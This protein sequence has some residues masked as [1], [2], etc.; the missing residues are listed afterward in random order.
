MAITKVSLLGADGKL[1]PAILHALLSGGFQVTVLKRASSKSKDAYPT[2]VHVAKVQDDFA[3]EALTPI[4]RGQDAVVVTIKGSQTELQGRIVQACVQAGV[5]R[6]I[7]ADFG[8]CDSA[9][10]KTQELVPLYKRKTELRE[11]LME[12]ARENPRFS[13]TSI[14]CGHFFDWDLTFLHVWIK[15]R[16][17]EI[18]DDGNTKWSASTLSRIAEATARVLLKPDVTRNQ[19]V[20]VQ[21][22]CV[23]Q[24]QVIQAYER[25]TGTSWHVDRLDSVQY[26]QQQKHMADKRDFDATENLVWLLGTVDANWEARE[27]F[28]MEKLG[29]RDEDLDAVVSRVVEE[30]Q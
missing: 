8:S 25:A 16:R 2:T 4:L 18:L 9:S 13:W 29:L 7:P 21:S 15:E 14:V 3:V 24:N 23:S 28:A 27:G 19:M 17:A 20:Y 12:L 22:F 26:I 11:Q 30:N 6:F 1:G 5:Q 10:A